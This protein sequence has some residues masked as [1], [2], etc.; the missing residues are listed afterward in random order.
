MSETVLPKDP[1]ADFLEL[2][3]IYKA[4][5]KGRM[6]TLEDDINFKKAQ[7]EENERIKTLAQET[8]VS[9]DSEEAVKS[10]DGLFV[11]RTPTN[12]SSSKRPFASI[13]D[14]EEEEE[15]DDVVPEKQVSKK[16][17]SGG[18]THAVAVPSKRTRAKALEKELRSNML[19]GIEAVLI[20][21]QK[22]E[23]D[24][25]AKAAE[26]EDAKNGKD[27]KGN[28]R[29]KK[30]KAAK[31]V[32]PTREKTGCM[33]NIGSLLTSNVYD[34]SNANLDQQALPVISEKNKKEFLS[35]LIAS[36]PLEDQKQA[37]SD[38]V[39]VV[40]ASKILSFRNVVP[41]GQGNWKL[42]G[43]RTSLYHYQVQGAAYMKMRETGEQGPWGGIL[44]G[45]SVAYNL[46]EIC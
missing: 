20:R 32:L 14:E 22:K 3:R 27:P 8:A 23:A 5:R 7:H 25:M 13:F 26:M 28:S 1:T 29:K 37:R 15:E 36:I 42:K 9:E 31:E 41:D 34:D 30:S 2:K 21:D 40:R 16:Q 33:N 10:D 43:M 18:P 12:G 35:S 11:S 17:E 6:N 44:A 45:E 19:A 38:R 4:K 46:E 39:D 24:K